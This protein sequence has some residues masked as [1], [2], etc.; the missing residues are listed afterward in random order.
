MPDICVAI[1][2]KADCR[3]GS[4]CDREMMLDSRE[5]DEA[6]GSFMPWP[7]QQ[8]HDIVDELL[9]LNRRKINTFA[10]AVLEASAFTILLRLWEGPRTLR[11]LSVELELEQSTVNRQVNA[12]I[13]HGY[14]ERFAVEGSASKM[15]RPTDR[16]RRV[17]DD[18]APG[19]PEVLLHELRAYNDAYERAVRAEGL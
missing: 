5:Q 15:L 9:R 19:R 2:R 12:A 10:G 3:V 16:L 8:I 1:R 17:F 7:S 18:L 13:K 14:V 4:G 11:E 6:D